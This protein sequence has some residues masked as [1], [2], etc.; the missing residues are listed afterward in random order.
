MTFATVSTCGM[1]ACGLVLGAYVL[2]RT[3]RAVG[4]LPISAAAAPR[5]AYLILRGRREIHW[6][7]LY[8]R[9]DSTFVLDASDT[10]VRAREIVPSPYLMMLG[11]G[12]SFVATD[13]AGSAR[14]DTARDHCVASKERCV[15]RPP[16]PAGGVCLQYLGKPK[17]GQLGDFE[18]LRCRLPIGIEART[19]CIKPD[20]ERF[21]KI[22]YDTF[23]S[24][25]DSTSWK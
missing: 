15:V 4:V 6:H 8:I 22:L 3:F 13:H 2:V 20:C 25:I 23:A 1:I 18:L 11:M 14:F 17:N 12:V 10:I 19:A 9:V 7:G 24:A 21:E 5:D 16:L